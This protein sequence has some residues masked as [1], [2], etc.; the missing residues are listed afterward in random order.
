LTQAV[1]TD[2]AKSIFEVLKKQKRV[3][4]RQLDSQ[5]CVLPLK[6]KSSARDFII[7]V[8]TLFY[9]T[10]KKDRNTSLTVALT[11]TFGLGFENIEISVHFLFH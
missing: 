6:K 5:H 9:A 7:E 11:K 2:T 8:Q 1:I 4:K 10:V 3:L